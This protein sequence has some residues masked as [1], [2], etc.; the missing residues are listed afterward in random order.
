[1][2]N[3]SATAYAAHLRV[4]THVWDVDST[5][6][7][8]Y[9]PLASVRHTWRARQDD[10]WPTQHDRTELVFAVVVEAGADLDDVDQGTTVH[11]TFTPAGYASPLVTFGGTVR[12]LVGYPH[13]LGM[14][15]QVTAVD[16]LQKLAEDYA[17]SLGVTT[18]Y[19]PIGTLWARLLQDANL[20]GGNGT[21]PALPDPWAGQSSRP[22]TNPTPPGATWPAPFNLAGSTWDVLRAVLQNSM[23][24][25]DAATGSTYTPRYQRPVLTYKLNAAGD[26]DPAQPFVGTWCPAGPRNAPLTLT[27]GPSG[28]D[29]AGGNLDAGVAAT[30]PTQWARERV[31]PN[32]VYQGTVPFERP[33]TGPDIVRRM[34]AS[35][36][37]NPFPLE[38]TNPY[39]VVSGIENDDQWSSSM[40]VV[41][42]EDPTVVGGWFTLPDAMRTLVAVENIDDRHTPTGTSRMLGMLGGASL[43]LPPGGRWSV[44]F[45]LRRTLPDP[46]DPLTGGWSVPGAITW[47]EIPPAVTWNDL[48]PS[49]TWDDL[50][51]IGD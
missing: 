14:V 49:L 15:Y 24:R 3:D 45:K 39:W 20:N 11:F 34:P 26:L 31:E 2:T 47:D 40:E 27:S 50:N 30:A 4:G 13:E 43:V 7:A 9:G 32:L 29:G 8:T 10:G 25:L 16:H 1:M 22:A 18:A 38:S 42:S 41:A 37:A 6:P 35:D 23:E 44:V 5:D 46:A 28:W 48:D 51:L 17:T 36:P 33:H 12:D 21:T 19:V